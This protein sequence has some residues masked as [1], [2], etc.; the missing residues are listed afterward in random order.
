MVSVV[1]ETTVASVPM[2]FRGLW[3]IPEMTA[4]LAMAA[5]SAP[6]ATLVY[7][8]SSLISTFLF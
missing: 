5:R 7:Y 6:M 1:G 4:Y 8:K 3:V 2:G